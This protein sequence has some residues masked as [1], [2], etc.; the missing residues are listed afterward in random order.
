M[1]EQKLKQLLESARGETPPAPSTGFDTRV[2]QAI[3]RDARDDDAESVSLLDQL[4]ALFPRL[5]FAAA[6]IIVLCVAGEL[7]A[8]ALQLPGVTEGVARASDHW[9]FAVNGF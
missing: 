9:L 5:A 8:S 4:N 3:R 1:N 6:A 2:M 7:I